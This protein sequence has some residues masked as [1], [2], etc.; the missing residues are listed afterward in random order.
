MDE[1]LKKDVDNIERE[2]LDNERALDED[3]IVKYRLARVYKGITQNDPCLH[4]D[5]KLIQ[6][7]R[8]D[9]EQIRDTDNSRNNI[10]RYLFGSVLL[11]P[12]C[13]I[14]RRTNSSNFTLRNDLIK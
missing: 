11:Y 2:Y 12:A 13:I 1:A 7:W 5:S 14:F 6:R 4:V 8:D 3:E 9:G 10:C